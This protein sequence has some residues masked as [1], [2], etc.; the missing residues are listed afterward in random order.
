[1][2]APQGQHSETPT[3]PAELWPA[4]I[5]G[6]LKQHQTNMTLSTIGMPSATEIKAGNFS[7][8]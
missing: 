2:E 6:E 3:R 8:Y 1:M 4:Q 7:K 5:R